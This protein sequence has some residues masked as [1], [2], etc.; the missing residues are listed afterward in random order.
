MLKF[1]DTRRKER[2]EKRMKQLSVDE[3]GDPIRNSEDALDKEEELS[4]TKVLSERQKDIIESMK[5]Q[6]E[7]GT[8]DHR[9]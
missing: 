8:F 5:E 9:H 1:F 2:E 7:K 4:E 6:M 3:E